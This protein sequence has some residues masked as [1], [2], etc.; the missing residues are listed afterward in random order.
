M[1]FLDTI[2]KLR[3]EYRSGRFQEESVV[4]PAL[5]ECDLHPPCGYHKGSPATREELE[6]LQHRFCPNC[7]EFNNHYPEP[8][9]YC[10]AEFESNEIQRIAANRAREVRCVECGVI[11]TTYV[12]PSCWGK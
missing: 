7:G 1:D 12:C 5:S 10:M 8:C 6:R 2:V 11:S 4:Q 3:E 9:A